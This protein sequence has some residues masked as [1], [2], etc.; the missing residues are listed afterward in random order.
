MGVMVLVRLGLLLCLLS[1]IHATKRATT[2][3][4]THPGGMHPQQQ[5]DFVRTKVSQREQPYYDAY[6]QLIKSADAAFNHS[7]HELADFSVPGYYVNATM[8]QKNS[9]GLQS[10]SFDAYACALA[11]HLSGFQTK[12]ADQSLRF[13]RAWAHVNNKYSDYDGT[14]VMAYSGPGMVI[15]GELLYHYHGWNPVDQQKYL[16]WVK[17]VYLKAS[18][19]IR[20]R[21]NNWADWGRF[22]SILSGYLLENSTEIAENIRLI[23]KDLFHKIAQDGHMPE[24]TKR[25]ANGIWYTYFSLAPITAA[26]WVAYRATNENLFTNFTQGTAS[27]KLALDYLHYY[28]M[29][30]NFW[31]WYP[32]P[33]KGSPSSWPGNL[34]EAMAPIYG[35]DSF[36]DY[37][38][39]ARPLIYR[40]HHF[41]WT[42][43]TLM[44]TQLGDYPKK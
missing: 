2:K 24:E 40:K 7:T 31:P 27:I 25:E 41:A 21:T 34:L 28:N 17:N 22:G 5:I 20:T 36:V 37:V 43:P 30:P 3:A 39:A 26:C 10:D 13:L 32:N 8:H 9:A 14:L 29:N 12:Y 4:F 1:Q 35:S 42:F 6:T 18:N 15:A 11:Y 38:K 19:E 44:R 23:K 16:Q 33:N